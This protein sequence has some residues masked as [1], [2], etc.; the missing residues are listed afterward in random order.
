MSADNPSG[1]DPVEAAKQARL[2]NAVENLAERKLRGE[3]GV[4]RSGGEPVA[5]IH[6]GTTDKAQGALIRE[7]GEAVKAAA[8]QVGAA[9]KEAGALAK[10]AVTEYLSEFAELAAEGAAKLTHAAA[11]LPEW[12][13]ALHGP[14]A[15]V[16]KGVVAFVPAVKVQLEHKLDQIRSDRGEYSDDPP[17]G[18]Q[19]DADP[20]PAD[21]A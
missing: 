5:T 20:P 6:A 18:R 19:E 8:K 4:S 9:V 1:G 2:E 3:L 21:R 13:P 10:E 11:S 16:V 14:N 12:A 7:D 15:E 17:R